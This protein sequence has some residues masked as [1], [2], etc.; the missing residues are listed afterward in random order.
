[1]GVV[2]KLDRSRAKY[3]M[4]YINLYSVDKILGTVGADALIAKEQAAIP[5]LALGK[6]KSSHTVGNLFFCRIKFASNISSWF[7]NSF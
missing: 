2:N 5:G 3:R 7:F 6:A 1:M 4:Q